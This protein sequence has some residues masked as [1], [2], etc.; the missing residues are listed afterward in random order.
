M[1]FCRAKEEDIGYE[2][3]GTCIDGVYVGNRCE[4]RL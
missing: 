2:L 4:K 3:S 1:K